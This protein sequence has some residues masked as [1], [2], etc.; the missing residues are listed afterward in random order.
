M[1][2]KRVGRKEWGWKG[3]H[4]ERKKGLGNGKKMRDQRE[5]IIKNRW[6]K[7]KRT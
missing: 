3:R 6:R 5:D 2:I 4:G 1:Q 7:R